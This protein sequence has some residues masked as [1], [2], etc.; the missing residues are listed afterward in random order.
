MNKTE[1]RIFF[2]TDVVLDFFSG[3]EPFA[4][5]AAILFTLAEEGKLTACV[6]ALTIANCY[7]ILKRVST[8]SQVMEKLMQFSTIAEILD[9]RKENIMDALR[10]GFKDF[11]DA[12]QYEVARGK[13]GMTAI[14]T[15]NI[16]DYRK[17]N[18]AIMTPEEYLRMIGVM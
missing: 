1:I 3:R 17:S 10:S 7:Y 4:G 13:P 16:K 5:Q 14:I 15:R 11:E 12:I 6:S 18:I 9:V 2:D 8:H